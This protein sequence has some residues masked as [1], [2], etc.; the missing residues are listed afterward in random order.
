MQF[1]FI[2]NIH[3]DIAIRTLTDLLYKKMHKQLAKS[4]S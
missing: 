2:S 1:T 3:P 4:K